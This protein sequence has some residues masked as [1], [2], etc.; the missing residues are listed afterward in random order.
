M[1]DV[2]LI[3]GGHAHLHVIKAFA[4]WR[5]PGVRLILVARDPASLYSGMLPGVIA[6][7]YSRE[8]AHIDLPRL[9]AASGVRFVHGEVCGLDRDTRHVLLKG[10]PPV[11]YDVVSL[12][13]GLVPDFSSI[14]GAQHAISVKPIGAF[15]PDLES[16][17]ARCRTAG[18]PRAIA[19]V[20]GGAG[21]VEL[22]L[23]ISARCVTEGIAAC[24]FTLV[25]DREILTSHHPR[26]RAVFRRIIKGRGV[27]LHEHCR[28]LAIEPGRIVCNTRTIS[29]DEV[30]LST[31]GAAPAWLAA[32]GLACEADGCLRVGA[33]LQSSTDPDVF[34]AGDCAALPSPREKSGVHAVRA[35]PPLAANLR[36]RIRGEPLRPWH[37]QRHALALISTGERYAVASR[38]ALTAQGAWLWAVK[39]LIDRRF[40]RQWQ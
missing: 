19:V 14:A 24:T 26:V 5:T 21:G 38:G 11:R 30:L 27:A 40:M 6:G 28:A 31:P 10:Q 22:L 32:T 35:G 20:G 36:R 18:S 37:P 33:T 23:S 3:G 17:L 8:D 13:V 39:D 25:T 16:L 34:A 29:A 4:A 15:L 1:S 9:C 12:D 7:L 2:V